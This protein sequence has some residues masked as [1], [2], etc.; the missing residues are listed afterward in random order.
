MAAPLNPW[1]LMP[2]RICQG[3]PLYTTDN[4][5]QGMHGHVT[6][7]PRSGLHLLQRLVKRHHR[8]TKTKA[9]CLIRQLVCSMTTVQAGCADAAVT[10]AHRR[11]VPKA[12]MH[13][14]SQ[15]H[16]GNSWWPGALE[17]RV[18]KE[19]GRSGKTQESVGSQSV[20]CKL[21]CRLQLKATRLHR[22]AHQTCQVAP[23]H[24]KRTTAQGANHFPCGLC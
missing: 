2:T 14:L 12:D 24:S 20:C 11:C 1:G 18:R 7:A 16:P 5:A 9:L 17:E 4:P 23:A 13:K 10:C 6:K 8:H 21:L 22:V 19:T 15:K 3:A